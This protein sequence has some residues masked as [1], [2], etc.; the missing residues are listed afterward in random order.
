MEGST[1][2]PF[3]KPSI[4][5]I[6]MEA[7]V[8]SIVGLTRGG[9]QWVPQFVI[10]LNEGKCIGCGR[11]FKVCPRDVLEMV[12]RGVDEMPDVDDDDEDEDDGDNSFMQ[13][14]DALDCIGCEACSRVCPKACFT[15]A[16]MPIAA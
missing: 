9:V 6:T 15:H 2:S 11:C 16:P 3:L 13:L 12:Q 4:E 14:K 5:V 7:V 10:A 1:D 8:Q